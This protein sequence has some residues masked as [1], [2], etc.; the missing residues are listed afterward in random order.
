MP[1]GCYFSFQC[2]S[3]LRMTG[4]FMVSLNKIAYLIINL[5]H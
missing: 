1:K 2:S 5:K 3:P 4:I